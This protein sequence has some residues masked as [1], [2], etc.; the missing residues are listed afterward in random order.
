[1]SGA[2]IPLSGRKGEGM[3]ALVNKRDVRLVAGR[4]WYLATNASRMTYAVAT[5]YRRGK[6][7]SVYMHQ[8]IRPSWK[9]VDH[10][11]CDGLDNRRRN[12]REATTAKNQMNRPM[13]RNNTSGFKGVCR[14]RK[15]WR[16]AIQYS[17]TAHLGDYSTPEAAAKAYDAAARK[18]HKRFARL[19]FP[20]RGERAARAHL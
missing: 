1:M 17:V 15:K 13:L 3:V 7:T 12:L 2:R 14:Y 18:F 6:R 4:K 20:R 19:N 16:A 5:I 10:K 11:N 8:I 9:E